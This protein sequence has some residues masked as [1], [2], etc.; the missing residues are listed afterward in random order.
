L[1]SALCCVSS[2]SPA[3]SLLFSSAIGCLSSALWSPTSSLAQSAPLFPQ[4]HVSSVFVF[5]DFVRWDWAPEPCFD[6]H[7][8]VHTPSASPSLPSQV[9]T[10]LPKARSESQ[11]MSMLCVNGDFL[12]GSALA[13]KTQVRMLCHREWRCSALPS[14][15]S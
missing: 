6:L 14:T 15:L 5:V 9:H 13:V 3:P 2:N 7:M 8:R 11:G 12:G 10:M 1:L 4:H